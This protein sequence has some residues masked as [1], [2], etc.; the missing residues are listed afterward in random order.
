VT[1]A[2]RNVSGAPFTKIPMLDD[3]ESNDGAA[4]DGVFGAS[5]LLNN[6]STEYYVYA[7]NNDAGQFS[8]LR[9]AHEF[10]TITA[11]SPMVGDIAINEFMASNDNTFADQDGDFDDWIELY[12]NTSESIDLSGY[13][14]SDNADELLQWAFP[15]GTLI[16]AN[17]Y[18]IIWA[19]EDDDQVGLHASFKLSA[20]A[21]S[22]IL[23]DANG[24]I[25]DQL[26]YA[27]QETDISFG[28][29]PN[30]IGDFRMMTATPD[31]ENT[32]VST[33]SIVINEFMASNDT[34]FADQDGDFDDWI[35]L[36]NNSSESIDLSGFHLS[37]DDNDATQWTFPAGT[38][39]EAEG[40]LIIWADE[41]EDQEGLHASFKLSASAETIVFADTSG[42]ILD[43][44][45]YENQETDISFGRFPN[46]VG[47]FQPMTPTP[48]AENNVKTETSP[49]VINEFMASNDSTFADQDGDFDDWIELYNN[50]T[51][52]IDLSGFYLSDDAGEI[53]QWT[54][55]AGTVIDGGGYLI[56]WADEDED[57]EGLHASFKLSASAETVVL[58]D[59]SG[60]IIDI[61]NYSDQETDISY[62]R[63]PNGVG[64]F[65]SMTPT[66][67]AEN[68]MTTSTS[69]LDQSELINLTISPNPTSGSFFLEVNG[70]DGKE[71]R[72]LIYRIDGRLVHNGTI[73]KDASFDTKN[74]SPGMYLI[75]VDNTVVKLIVNK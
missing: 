68:N 35:E 40:Y 42:A 8:P 3:G 41:D 5:I 45:N 70:N 62:G 51:A 43:Q 71:S 56:I 15:E 46:G 10:Y 63:F 64:D 24:V 37:D 26:S 50:S 31:T 75:N 12:N 58:A 55:P 73:M 9:A 52:S 60:A 74:W 49:V 14:L 38:I 30:G 7:E 33:S 4:G 19:D 17:G 66:P 11:S 34:T 18:L 29:F 54:F 39:I 2:Y 53:T 67:N 47:D 16:D 22:V 27:D 6:I 32:I 25:I 20:S 23:S 59:T 69:N 61:I 48:N 28:R 21:E 13:Y 57:Q 72:L 44:I 65:Q 1:L 36:Y